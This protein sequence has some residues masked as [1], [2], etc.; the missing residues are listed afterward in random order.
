MQGGTVLHPIDSVAT[1][2]RL[3]ALW[4]LAGSCEF[5]EQEQG[6]IVDALLG[7]IQIQANR[8][9]AETLTPRRVGGEQL[10]QMPWAHASGMG[11]QG[12]PLR[13]LGQGRKSRMLHR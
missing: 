3:D 5:K 9:D 11:Q 6:F 12:L 7:V 8:L 13:A 10:T 2:H 1:K 4:Q